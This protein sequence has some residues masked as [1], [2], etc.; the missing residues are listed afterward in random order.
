MRNLVLAL[1][2]V[3]LPATLPA[4]SID[5]V[6]RSTVRITQGEG[7]CTGFVVSASKG[8]VLTARHC[9]SQDPTE[10][11]LLVDDKPTTVLKLSEAFA[12]LSIEPASKPPLDI[13]KDNIKV[14]EAV[15][16]YGYGYGWMQVLFRHVA[17]WKEGDIITDGALVPGMSGGPVLDDKGQVVGLIQMTT[18][19][20]GA[21]CGVGEIREFLKGGR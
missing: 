16:A 10:G 12:L 9:V 18:N 1:L 21:A 3:L 6:L 13:R 15:V 11:E 5:Q 20:L 2:L 7:V 19:V 14:G 8:E 17:S 4:T